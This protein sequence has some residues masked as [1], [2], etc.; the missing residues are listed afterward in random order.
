MGQIKP[1]EVNHSG[2]DLCGMIGNWADGG[3]ADRQLIIYGT[4]LISAGHQEDHGGC[5]LDVD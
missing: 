5:L 1:T 3:L 2:L 4:H